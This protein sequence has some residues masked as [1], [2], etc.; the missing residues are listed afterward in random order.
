M[1][2]VFKIVLLTALTFVTPTLFVSCSDDDDNKNSSSSIV[3]VPRFKDKSYGA[4][5]DGA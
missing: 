3:D 5:H 1:K 4:S 2:N